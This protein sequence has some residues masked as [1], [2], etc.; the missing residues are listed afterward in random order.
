LRIHT[1]GPTKCSQCVQSWIRTNTN[2]QT[3]RQ[4]YKQTTLVVIH[5]LAD[6]CLWSANESTTRL[7]G[8]L[9][10][11]AAASAA[12]AVTRISHLNDLIET[13]MNVNSVNSD[14]SSARADSEQ[15]PHLDDLSFIIII[16]IADYTASY[17][18][19][20]E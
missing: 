18:Q 5:V 10:P 1:V 11:T 19:S 20:T 4:S 12:A 3:E 9:S 14:S 16:I 6:C 7:V 13:T 8:H 2:S 17:A 15:S